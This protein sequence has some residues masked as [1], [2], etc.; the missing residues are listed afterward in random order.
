MEKNSDEK[1]NTSVS[2]SAIEKGCSTKRRQVIYNLKRLSEI[3]YNG[4]PLVIIEK[5]RVNRFRSKTNTYKLHKIFKNFEFHTSLMDLPEFYHHSDGKPQVL[6]D[7]QAINYF[8]S[9]SSSE[10]LSKQFQCTPYNIYMKYNIKKKKQHVKKENI[11]MIFSITD[12]NRELVELINNLR[13]KAEAVPCKAVRIPA[14]KSKNSNKRMSSDLMSIMSEFKISEG[15]ATVDV[16]T[17]S[18]RCLI[19]NKTKE[20][21]NYDY[22]VNRISTAVDCPTNTLKGD[23]GIKLLRM[24]DAGSSKYSSFVNKKLVYRYET[25][26]MDTMEHL[27]K[28]LAEKLIKFG[29]MLEG[30][31][32]AINKAGG[33]IFLSNRPISKLLKH[34]DPTLFGLLYLLS[35]DSK[36]LN[37]VHSISYQRNKEYGF[38]YFI[39]ILGSAISEMYQNSSSKLSNLRASVN[40]MIDILVDMRANFQSL[41][42]SKNVVIKLSMLDVKYLMESSETKRLENE[43]NMLQDVELKF[44]SEEAEKMLNFEE[45]KYNPHI[46]REVRAGI[47][48]SD[49]RE[50]KSTVEQKSQAYVKFD[51]SGEYIPS[52]KKELKVNQGIL[53]YLE[54]FKE[55]IVND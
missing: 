36:L 46:S 8:K 40:A 20:N 10:Y 17:E 23:E 48:I 13:S 41:S 50:F 37:N 31:S 3:S 53:K 39:K 54:Q 21:Y 22:L 47:D 52:E 45:I 51:V 4:E 44:N 27:S 11:E 14:M 12:E 42:A 43:E 28:R 7:P 34:L 18:N 16:I 49:K 30:E 15:P 2:L 32:I 33:Y 25:E 5:V 26:K 38:N 24:N 55:K 9:S 35:F 6:V 29:I 1:N 19:L